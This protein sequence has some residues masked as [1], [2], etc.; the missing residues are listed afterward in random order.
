MADIKTQSLLYHLTDIQ[1]LES[2]LTDGLKPRS[3]L[4]G[5]S[6]VAD[7]DILEKRK[8]LKL[9][10]HV[11]FHFF[12]GNPF[13]G[14]VQIASE[15][16]RFVLITITRAHAK[17]NNWKVIPRHPLAGDDIELMDY[18]E[19]FASIDWAKM[20]ERDYTDPGSKSI[21]MA[22]CLSS[23]TVASSRFFSIYVK[24]AV[25]AR[26]VRELLNKA[27][28]TPHLNINPHFFVN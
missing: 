4:T 27:G 3:E 17:S 8:K 26:E 21:C 11:P 28:L 7:P 18:D 9:E 16:G 25:V 1:N 19:G 10:E 2:I 14:G 13:D 20:N 22:E 6:D 24:D 12:G 5:F 15:G 23:N